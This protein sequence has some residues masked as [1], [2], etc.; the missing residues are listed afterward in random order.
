MQN[1]IRNIVE[2][3]NATAPLSDQ[4]IKQILE[5]D[6]VRIARRTVAKY[7]DQLGIP[8]PRVRKRV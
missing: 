1:K 7:R 5:K 6:G 4:K 2:G 3:E 8:P